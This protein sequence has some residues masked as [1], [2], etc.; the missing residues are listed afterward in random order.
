MAAATTRP[1]QDLRV[2]RFTVDQYERMTEVGILGSED[3]VELLEGW[4]VD[5]M[6]QGPRHNVAVDLVRNALAACLTGDWQVRE[7]KATRLPDSEPEP[8]V[9]IVRGPI[10]RYLRR[11]PAAEDVALA[12]EVSDSSLAEDRGRKRRIYARSRIPAYWIVNLVEG[13]VEVH[14]EPR[15]G[16][17]PAYRQRTDYARGQSIPLVVAGA[18]LGPVAVD[19]LLP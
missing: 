19:D 8:D 18:T 13:H 11:H 2:H 7:Q 12:V 3:R 17:S 5:K 16:R 9:A 14:T 10:R 1:E 15:G 6:T 4:I